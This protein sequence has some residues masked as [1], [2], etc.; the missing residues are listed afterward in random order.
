[1]DVTT[2]A[3]NAATTDMDLPQ[4]NGTDLPGDYSDTLENVDIDL[5]GSLDLNL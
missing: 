2:P 5:V 3:T 4:H 1:M